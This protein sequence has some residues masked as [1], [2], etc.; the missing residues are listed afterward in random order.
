MLAQL[1]EVPEMVQPSTGSTVTFVLVVA[2][3][4][5]AF[6]GAVR[7]I[8]R[9]DGGRWFPRVAA[10]TFAWLG[11][12]AAA[13]GS[14][15]L[16]RQTLPPPVMIFFVA[17]MAVALW[18][19]LSRL[20]ARLAAGVPL[21]ALVAFHGFRLPL[22]LVLHAWYEQGV[23]PVQMTYAGHNFDIVTGILAVL[24]GLWLWRARP[25]EALA[26]KVALG[27]NVVG[28][29]LLITVAS[30][31]V[32]SSPIPLRQYANDPPVLL[33]MHVPYGWIVP[34]CVGAALAGHVILFRR[35]RQPG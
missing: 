33:A 17:S 11:L 31:A 20:G 19:G 15:M 29:G 24:V 16:A 21:A 18:V 35:L 26:N 2:F 1:S 8:D 9:A 28:L 14:G 3:V 12:T 6:L 30:I 22:E 5:A 32:M 13:S 27:F 25:P 23:L 10:G 7:Q 34:F 4:V